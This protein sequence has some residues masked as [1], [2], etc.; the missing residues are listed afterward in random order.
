VVAAYALPATLTWMLLGLGVAAVSQSQAAASRAVL[1]GAAL[2]AAL[3]YSGYYGVS[4]A[5]GRPGV[6]PPGRSWQVPQTMVIG[7]SPRRRIV[8]WGAVLGPGFLTRNPYA[9]FGLLPLILI[10]AASFG[11]SAGLVVGAGVGI[12]HGT[13]R[14]LAL[15]RDVRDV[16][17]GRDARTGLAQPDVPPRGPVDDHM[18]LLLKTVRWRTV[19][20]YLLLA[21]AG[22]AVATLA[23]QFS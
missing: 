4:E 3:A 23:Y 19:D 10:A 16:R 11:W 21:V 9:G 14:A 20:G 15:L 2:V 17:A 13:A 5:V 22:T 18:E 6:R 7:T 12:A 1:G 8:V